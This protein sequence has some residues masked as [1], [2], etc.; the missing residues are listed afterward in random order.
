MATRQSNEARSQR[1]I[2]A[3][4]VE[5]RIKVRATRI[6]YYGEKR[7]RVGDVF[8]LTPM[9]VEFTEPTTVR[10]KRFPVEQFP[11]GKKFSKGETLELTAEDQLSSNWMERVSDR[12]PEKSTSAP[13]ALA[14]ENEALLGRKR[15][16]LQDARDV[17]DENGRDHTAEDD[18]IGARG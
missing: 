2:D 11:N 12:T 9:S 4:A 16:V 14:L 3:P 10:G 5:G 1:V 18:P 6:G 17:N 8:W 13:Q 7:R 15:S